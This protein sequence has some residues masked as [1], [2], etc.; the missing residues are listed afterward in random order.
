M[1]QGFV[2]VIESPS[3]QDLLDGRTEGRALGE[4]LKLAEIPQC[5]SLATDARTLTTALGE[6]LQ[7]AVRHYKSTPI[8]HFSAHGNSNGIGLTGGQ[9]ICW[10]DLEEMLRPIHRFF[11]NGLLVCMSSCE[12]SSAMQMAMVDEPDHAFWALVSHMGRPSW[13]DA[14]VGFIA[15]YHRFFKGHGIEAAVQ[16]MQDATGDTNF[17]MWEGARIKANWLARMQQRIDTAIAQ[18]ASPQGQ[19]LGALSGIGRVDR[20]GGVSGGALGRASLRPSPDVQ[21]PGT[22][23]G[24]STP[25]PLGNSS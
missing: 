3:P 17:A 6:R 18:P 15:F 4:A 23:S 10:S 19:G 8:L 20:I 2:H 5:Y 25:S 12:S 9:F 1:V 22:T 16:A 7:A 14:A 13:S 21:Q 11:D 24:D